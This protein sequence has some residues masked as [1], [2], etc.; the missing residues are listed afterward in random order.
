[1]AGF[2]LISIFGRS[3]NM[4]H[5]NYFTHCY[6]KNAWNEYKKRIFI[7]SWL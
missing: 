4:S 7:C 5:N 3:S 6:A 1:L 2:K